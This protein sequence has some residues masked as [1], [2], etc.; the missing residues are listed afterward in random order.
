MDYGS[1]SIVA[2]WQLLCI[3][4][5]G[6][7]SVGLVTRPWLTL[8]RLP[9][10]GGWGWV[11]RWLAAEPWGFLRLLLSYWQVEPGSRAAGCGAKVSELVC[12]LVTRAASRAF[13][14]S[15]RVLC[16]PGLDMADYRAHSGPWAD[17]HTMMSKVAAQ[18]VL[19]LV[20]IYWWEEQG[21]QVSS[22]RTVFQSCYQSACGWGQGSLGDRAGIC[23]LIGKA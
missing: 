14:N 9:A 18:G 3:N 23:P 1:P 10:A 8:R 19:R 7:P 2:G 11:T 17:I 6:W 5:C 21:P 15:S 4:R 20:L 22:D 12:M 16:W 13:Q